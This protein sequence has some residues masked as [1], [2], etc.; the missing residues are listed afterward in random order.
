MLNSDRLLDSLVF[1]GGTMLRLCHGL[2]RY[3]VDLDFYFR[4]ETDTTAY[5]SRVKEVV[6]AHFTLTDAHDKYN[7]IL[8][9]LT[10]SRHSSRLKMEVNK[11]RRFAEVNREIAYSPHGDIQVLLNTLTLDQM[12]RNKAEALLDRKEI[13]DAY[14]MEFLMRKG[15]ALPADER[16]ARTLLAVVEAFTE[17]DYKVK[18]GSL[19]SPDVRQHFMSYRFERLKE[20]LLKR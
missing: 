1:G 14:D 10:S 16:T 17:M 2:D 19:L 5:F 8:I 9:E 18:L 12:M 15:V 20:N 4:E 6:L 13:R 7:T 11:R 3:S